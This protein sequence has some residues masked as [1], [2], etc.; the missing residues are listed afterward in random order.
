MTFCESNS[1]THNSIKRPL[2]RHWARP[3]STFL[4][5]WKLKV[6]NLFL[7]LNFCPLIKFQTNLAYLLFQTGLNAKA[8]WFCEFFYF[9]F[10]IFEMAKIEVKLKQGMGIEERKNGTEPIN[11]NPSPII[12]SLNSFVLICCAI[13]LS[14]VPRARSPV[15]TN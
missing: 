3:W 4:N 8:L 15:F 12:T 6:F 7:F 1:S 9:L 10:W 14:P 13:F 11:W 2:R 5:A